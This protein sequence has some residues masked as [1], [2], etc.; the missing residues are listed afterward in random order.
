MLPEAFKGATRRRKQVACIFGI[1]NTMQHIK[2]QQPTRVCFELYIFLDHLKGSKQIW[3]K[4]D[5]DLGSNGL[6]STGLVPCFFFVV[7]ETCQSMRFVWDL[8]LFRCLPRPAKDYSSCYTSG[9][10][11]PLPDQQWL[12]VCG[13]PQVYRIFLCQDVPK[14]KFPWAK[15]LPDLCWCVCL[16]TYQI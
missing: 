7:D 9:L 2:Q 16:E 4:P 14:L 6:G 5:P 15:C 12:K 13:G 1:F 3:T 10:S 11:D 8:E